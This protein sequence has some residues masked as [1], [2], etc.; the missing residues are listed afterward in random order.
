MYHCCEELSLCD[1][2][3]LRASSALY[4]SGQSCNSITNLCRKPHVRIL[5]DLTAKVAHTMEGDEHAR[6]DLR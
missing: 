2:A 4:A 3:N 1:A 6:G 5:I